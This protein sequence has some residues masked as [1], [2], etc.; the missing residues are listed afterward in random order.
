MKLGF[1]LS[2][3]GQVHVMQTTRWLEI[4][5]TLYVIKMS[6]NSTRFGRRQNREEIKNL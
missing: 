6:K 2:E 5:S 1:K 4:P 3:T